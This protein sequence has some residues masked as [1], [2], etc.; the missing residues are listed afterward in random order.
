M[1]ALDIFWRQTCLPPKELKGLRIFGIIV[2]LVRKVIDVLG[3]MKPAA[4]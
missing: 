1:G 2:E 3:L 4:S